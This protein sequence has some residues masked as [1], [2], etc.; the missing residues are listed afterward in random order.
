MEVVVTEIMLQLVVTNGNKISAS[1]RPPWSRKKQSLRVYDSKHDKPH[2]PPK[3]TWKD[4]QYFSF[5][6]NF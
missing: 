3:C 4:S 5:E 6:G 1:S 2:C